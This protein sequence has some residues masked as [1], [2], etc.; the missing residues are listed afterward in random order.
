MLDLTGTLFTSVALPD[1]TLQL[2]DFSG[3]SASRFSV[4]GFGSPL[5]V[6]FGE[7]NSVV[8]RVVPIE[9][10]LTEFAQDVI[11]HDLH[12][13]ISSSLDAKLDAMLNALDDVNAQNYVAALNAMSGFSN[14]VEAQRGKALTQG[15]AN[16]LIANGQIIIRALGG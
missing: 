5:Y 3:Y 4:T 9:E 7:V 2:G 15:E 12:A 16:R 1:H 14:A 8:G 10:L 13:G 11:S 6:V